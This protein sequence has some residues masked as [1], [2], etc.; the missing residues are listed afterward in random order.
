MLLVNSCHSLSLKKQVLVSQQ[1]TN[2]L[3]GNHIFHDLAFFVLGREKNVIN[4]SEENHLKRKN[5]EP[6]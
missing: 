4:G 3:L 2:M 5:Y 1:K 6:L